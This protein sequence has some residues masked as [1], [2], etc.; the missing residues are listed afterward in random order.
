MLFIPKTRL[1]YPRMM[2]LVGKQLFVHG[3]GG[4][5]PPIVRNNR[6]KTKNAELL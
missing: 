2:A 4:K 6:K 1:L 3:N 5:Q